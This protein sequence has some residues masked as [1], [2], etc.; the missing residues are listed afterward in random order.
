MNINK[1]RFGNEFVVPYFFE[2]GFARQQFVATSHHV[3]E[4]LELAGPQNDWAITSLRSST[5]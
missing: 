2:E 3:F 1:V 5:H 4:Q